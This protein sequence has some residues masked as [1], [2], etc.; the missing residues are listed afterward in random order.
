MADNI[1][2]KS[3]I[4]PINLHSYLKT[5]SEI[6]GNSF[7]FI[8]NENIEN[9]N[10]YN[11][12]SLCGIPYDKPKVK[13]I[14]N[15]FK[16]ELLRK[17]Q[18]DDIIIHACPLRKICTI[19][20]IEYMSENIGY[21]MMNYS[22]EKKVSQSEILETY[23]K[24]IR[25]LL[26]LIH[27][28][29]QQFIESEINKTELESV[30][31]QLNENMR[32]TE[33]VQR[34]FRLVA[35]SSVNWEY[36]V[37]PDGEMEFVSPSCFNVT[38]YTNEE[39][40]NDPSLVSDIILDTN[41]YDI[42]NHFSREF[43][44]EVGV[45]EFELK[46]RDK[47]GSIKWMQHHCSPLYD[48]EK[49]YLGR[50][51][52]NKDITEL[53]HTQILQSIQ[54]N[55]SIKAGKLES[56][57]SVL[58]SLVEELLRF[59]VLNCGTAYVKEGK[60]FYLKYY[61]N[62]SEKFFKANEILPGDHIYIQDLKRKKYLEVNEEDKNPDYI[63]YREI[64]HVLSFISIAII[65]DNNLIGIISVGSQNEKSVNPMISSALKIIF[66]QLEPIIYNIFNTIQLN[67]KTKDLE[68]AKNAA[69]RANQYKN[70]FL[71]NVSHEI[72]TPMNAILGFSEIL[73]EELENSQH[74]NFVDTIISNS[75]TL[76]SL[77][78][79][80]L[81]FS[82]IEAGKIKYEYSEVYLEKLLNEIQNLF[83]IKASK[84]GI[85]FKIISSKKLPSMIVSDETRIRQVLINLVSNAIK[86]TDS[87]KVI[88]KV[89]SIIKSAKV[90]LVF[91]IMDSGIGIF[92]DQKEKIFESFTQQ[93]GQSNRRYGGTGL[94]L[95]ISQKL[96][97][98]LNGNIRV[99]SI[100]GK[101]SIFR[102]T[103]HSLDYEIKKNRPVEF[104]EKINYLFKNAN[105]IYGDSYSEGRYLIREFLKEQPF[106]LM[107]AENI[108]ELNEL[109]YKEKPQLILI[110]SSLWNDLECELIRNLREKPVLSNVPI[111]GLANPG[112]KE[113]NCPNFVQKVLLKPVSKSNLL[114]ALKKYIPIQEIYKE[115][116]TNDTNQE[117]FLEDLVL[118]DY[119]IKY[120]QKDL[121]KSYKKLKDSLIIQDVKKFSQKIKD[122]AKLFN[123]NPLENYSLRLDEQID[124]YNIDGIEQLLREFT[125]FLKKNNAL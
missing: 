52:T 32:E 48:E 44:E 96:A 93:D 11:A 14:C 38:G 95:A 43:K 53:K 50:R 119:L 51:I 81:D 21:L 63:P 113:K 89:Y 80:I 66:S 97:R 57:D 10:F 42:L 7:L 20:K 117:I 18:S 27:K 109:L 29:I 62:I 75:N 6:T 13:E 86:F 33:L 85:Q 24:E 40:L 121:M 115:D 72:R 111:I 87:G 54:K 106:H 46:I 77:I 61:A 31:F 59:D 84:K 47:N 12:D 68:E 36:W 23:D 19:I 110:D 83:F 118:P 49:N 112:E 125:Q 91:A 25:R 1:M 26:I 30:I 58:K 74:R 4:D 65:V 101:G 92:A 78:N 98:D 45:F 8:P 99:N 56:L 71:A 120:L 37:K 64:D 116:I 55:F 5:I 17:A 39:F 69:E 88:L 103:L 34:K 79:D 70:E 3:F 2:Q 16:K 104:N 41:S 67:K 35:E 15:N 28:M 90:D 22:V 105:I 123:V 9:F 94:G 60:D 122:S 100:A 76:L 102:F 124:V 73:K 107:E 82:K 114:S 108:K